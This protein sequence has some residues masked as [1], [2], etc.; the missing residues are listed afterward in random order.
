M[1][2]ARIGTSREKRAKETIMST[3]GTRCFE[4]EKGRREKL[5]YFQHLPLVLS[6]VTRT[7]TFPSTKIDAR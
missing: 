1:K 4:R 6:H 2:M 3:V 5:V 7:W